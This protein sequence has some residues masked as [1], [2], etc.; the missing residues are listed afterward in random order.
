[1]GLYECIFYS[2]VIICGASVCIAVF[3]F[4]SKHWLLRKNKVNYVRG[5]KK[6][7]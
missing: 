4:A 6:V 2:V 3:Y 7:R 5:N 1:M